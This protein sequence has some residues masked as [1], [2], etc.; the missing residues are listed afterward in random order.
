MSEATPLDHTTSRSRIVILGRGGAGKSTLARRLAEFDGLPIV[1]LDRLFWT[2]D[3]RPTPLDEWVRIQ[4]K[5]TSQ[6]RW[7]IDGDLGPYDTDL[8]L[9]LATADTVIILNYS[10]WLC[11]WRSWRRGPE[12]RE[13]WRWLVRY[14]KASLP[15]IR[16]AIT[17]HAGGARVHVL[18]NPAQLKRFLGSA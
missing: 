14:R 12:T 8:H 18:R 9:R 2:A 13:F 17:A 5:V 4:R 6:D 3:L 7:I 10:L 16:S 11:G 15:T 1:E